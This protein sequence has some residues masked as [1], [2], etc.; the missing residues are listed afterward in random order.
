MAAVLMPSCS[1][2]GGV[3]GRGLPP[4]RMADRQ[5]RARTFWK[6]LG[7]TFLA[8]AQ[9]SWLA[10]GDEVLLKLVVESRRVGTVE[11]EGKRSSGIWPF[12]T[13]ETG[14]LETKRWCIR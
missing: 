6:R 1:S 9:Q 7:V 14:R 5:E 3:A 12:R 4:E 13:S 2:T 10:H 11:F 8:S